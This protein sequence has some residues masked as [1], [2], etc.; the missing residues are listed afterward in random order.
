[1]AIG[2][3]YGEHIWQVANGMP[4]VTYRQRA[5]PDRDQ[6]S[7]RT[8]LAG[9]HLINSRQTCPTNPGGDKNLGA[10]PVTGERLV[11]PTPAEETSSV[12]AQPPEAPV[13][14]V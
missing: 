2:A 12:A 4:A 1:M 11:E 13:I 7:T 10:A 3:A 9:L 6:R 8:D 14:G 5:A